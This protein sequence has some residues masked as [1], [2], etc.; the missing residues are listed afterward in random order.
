MIR[1]HV[2][3][4][5]VTGGDKGIVAGLQTEIQ[6]GWIVIKFMMMSMTMMIVFM[7][8]M[9][10]EEGRARENEKVGTITSY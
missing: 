1:T 2:K 6:S 8:T 9:E 10:E 3:S 4:N 7:M 5:I